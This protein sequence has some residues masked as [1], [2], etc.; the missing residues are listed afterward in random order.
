MDNEK[1]PFQGV[2]AYP[3][4][5]TKEDG[6]RLDEERFRGLLDELIKGGS[7]GIVVL[8]STGA[9]GSFSEDERKVLAQ[10]AAEH[11][12]GRVPFL[13]GTGGMTTDDSIRMSMHA[14]SVGADGLQIVPMS[15]WPL[16][17]SE[18]YHHYKEIAAAVSI[19]IVVHNC[20]ALTGI[21]MKPAL[22]ARLVEIENVRYLKEGSGDLARIS[23]LIHLTK[24]AVTIFQDQEV[25]ALQG[26]IAGARVWASM[27]P[28]I[29]AEQCVQLFD[30]AVVQKDIDRS[31]QLFDK[32]FPLIEFVS[33]R[34]GIR[35]L[36]TALEIMGRSV[37]PPRRPI[38]M[39]GNDDRLR[40]ESLLRECGAMA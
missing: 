20:P 4:T 40:L 5:P 36:H 35:T 12:N 14:E 22:L 28:N 26:L 6:R 17:E 18:I 37:G 19:P 24:G 31:R 10:V 7:H 2:F 13:V 21:D 38:R 30:L 29:I 3:L 39:L 32:V 27:M 34:S 15:H 23:T 16:T 8:G 1:V 11:I 9:I 33:Q 25:T